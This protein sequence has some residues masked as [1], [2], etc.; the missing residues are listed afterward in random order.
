VQ[1]GHTGTGRSCNGHDASQGRAV[2]GEYDLGP[3]SDKREQFREL[4]L[5]I[6][7]IDGFRGHS[8]S[9]AAGILAD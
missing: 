9:S 6:E 2:P 1:A 8:G 7:D 5:G 4:F 3:G